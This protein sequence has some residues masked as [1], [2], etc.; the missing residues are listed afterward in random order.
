M[1]YLNNTIVDQY[2]KIYGRMATIEANSSSEAVAIYVID[3]IY[4]Q[5]IH[6]IFGNVYSQIITSQS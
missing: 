5:I 2:D 6:P 4:E 1:K 3:N